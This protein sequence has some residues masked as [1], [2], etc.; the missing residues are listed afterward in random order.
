MERNAECEEHEREQI[1]IFMHVPETDTYKLNEVVHENWFLNNSNFTARFHWLEDWL[2]CL[3]LFG[4]SEPKRLRKRMMCAAVV[5]LP[6]IVGS[7]IISP[8]KSDDDFKVST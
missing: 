2:R 5:F 1:T 7:K 8:L 6:I 4:N 3:V